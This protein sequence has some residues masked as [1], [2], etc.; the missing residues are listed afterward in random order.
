MTITVTVHRTRRLMCALAVIVFAGAS[1]PSPAQAGE[2]EFAGDLYHGILG[3]APDT[4][5]L[6]AGEAFL[7]RSCREQGLAELVGAFFASSE[8]QTNRPHTAEE[9]VTLLYRI[10]LKRNP[11]PAG[12]AA[13]V[14][15]LRRQRLELATQ[16]FIASPEFQGALPNRRDPVAVS[17]LV[18]RFYQE[19]LGRT[20]DDDGLR[21][22]VQYIVSTQ[23]LEGVAQAFLASQEFEAEP[24]TFQQLITVL[25]RAFLA[26]NPDANGLNGWQMSLLNRLL[27]LI[28][29]GFVPSGEF[30]S[31]VAQICGGS[32]KKGFT[33]RA[34]TRLMDATVD[35]TYQFPFCLPVPASGGVCPPAS[36]TAL[37]PRGGQA[38]YTFERDSSL[39]P[40]PS[41]LTL[42]SSSGLLTGTP[43]SA[44]DFT[45]G[46]CATDATGARSCDKVALRVKPTP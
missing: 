12:L 32:S 45:F 22:W 2:K 34:P 20:P 43:T 11:D 10:L 8:F 30:K 42:E 21:G 29:D 31:Q 17:A 33:F 19:I 7:K 6:A 9:L 4:A 46:I 24:L 1:V 26:R 25:Y 23:D 15:E 35:A 18:T 44:G 28:D 14:A 39:G 16:G 13:F 40:L 36:T 3:R 27:K 41:G 38:P 37:N 5:G